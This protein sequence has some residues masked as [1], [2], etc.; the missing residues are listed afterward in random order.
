[1]YSIRPYGLEDTVRLPVAYLWKNATTSGTILVHHVSV[2][3]S[4]LQA[5]VGVDRAL[6]W[7]N[8]NAST[9]ASVCQS[10]VSMPHKPGTPGGEFG[11]IVAA[12]FKLRT[13]C[14]LQKHELFFVCGSVEHTSWF[15]HAAS[16][17]LHADGPVGF[18]PLAKL[19]VYLLQP[20]YV[21][22]QLPYDKLLAL[23][24]ESPSR[25]ITWFKV[26]TQFDF[27]QSSLQLSGAPG[28]VSCDPFP[29]F[30]SCVPPNSIDSKSRAPV[31]LRI[32]APQTRIHRKLLISLFYRSSSR[33]DKH[34]SR[35]VVLVGEQGKHIC[36][37]ADLCGYHIFGILIRR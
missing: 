27:V 20:T 13:I 15:L 29:R 34:R 22:H 14:S 31:R 21:P 24:T 8:G 3:S 16:V 9:F 37:A 1:M 19:F 4:N 2:A 12:S 17:G 6:D 32:A 18:P 36:I 33:K 30:L 5:P 7:Q 26:S 23:D 25:F 28:F 11:P 10:N 35:E